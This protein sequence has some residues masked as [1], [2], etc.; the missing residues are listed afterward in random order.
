MLEER[1][2]RSVLEGIYS[3]LDMESKSKKINQ[4]LAATAP[5]LSAGALSLA[6]SIY[7]PILMASGMVQKGL[8]SLAK[9]TG[10]TG[11]DSLILSRDVNHKSVVNQVLLQLEKDGIIPV[12]AID[13]L[14][15][16]TDDDLLSDFFEGQQGWFQSKRCLISLSFT[17]GRSLKN[18]TIHSVKRFCSIQEIDGVTERADFDEIV[19]R[20]FRTGISEI[21]KNRTA[22]EAASRNILT[23]HMSTQIINNFAPHISLM[24]EEVYAGIKHALE[25]GGTATRIEDFSVLNGAGLEAPT[26]LERLILDELAK[27][28]R[29]PGELATMLEK[30]PPEISRSLAKMQKTEWVG[31]EGSWTKNYFIKQKGESARHL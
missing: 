20:R 25:H 10:M 22:V 21:E 11:I 13:E 17:Y 7:P 8:E 29:R 27:G 26:R 5:W 12:F 9:K 4:V 28:R 24:L 3:T 31:S 14:D 1:F 2:Y 18:A 16:M 30:T 19:R 15:K 6:G 23:D